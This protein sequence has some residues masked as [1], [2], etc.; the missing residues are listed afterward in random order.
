MYTL[1]VSSVYKNMFISIFCFYYFIFHYHSVLIFYKKIVIWKFQMQNK[2]LCTRKKPECFLSNSALYVHSFNEQN[3]NVITHN[4][5]MTQLFI[6]C[7][8]LVMNWTACCGV[9]GSINVFLHNMTLYRVLLTAVYILIGAGGVMMLVGF[10]GCFGA[11]KESQCLL[12]SVGKNCEWKSAS[13]KIHL[14]PV[15]TW[16][17]MLQ[18]HLFDLFQNKAFLAGFLLMNGN[19]YQIVMII[20]VN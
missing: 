19:V 7:H 1:Y 16:S 13:P 6:F 14:H 15:F 5:H 12:G 2:C 18:K 8:H 11:V 20:I 3:M 4:H 17:V 10:F 9:W